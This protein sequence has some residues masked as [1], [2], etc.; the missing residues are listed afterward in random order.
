MF[1]HHLKNETSKIKEDEFLLKHMRVSYPDKKRQR[2][3]KRP[4]KPHKVTI[5]YFIRKR[6]NELFPVCA[7]YFA[8][9]TGTNLYN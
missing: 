9:I 4:I 1:S 6:N 7:E 5:K 3:E 8:N 2:F